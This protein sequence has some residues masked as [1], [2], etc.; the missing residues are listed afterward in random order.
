M[1]DV[2]SFFV[3]DRDDAPNSPEAFVSIVA[4][5][6]N[7]PAIPPSKSWNSQVVVEP[8]QCFLQQRIGILRHAKTVAQ[9]VGRAKHS[10]PTA[11]QRRTQFGLKANEAWHDDVVS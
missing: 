3:E 4:K 2:Q 7:R 11:G 5:P 6:K 10:E 1:L 9:R 8:I